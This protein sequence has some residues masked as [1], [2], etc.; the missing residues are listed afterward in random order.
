MSHVA[1]TEDLKGC[2]GAIVYWTFSGLTPFENLEQEWERVGLEKANLPKLPSPEL[3]LS[4]TAHD[5]ASEKFA[6]FARQMGPG[7]WVLVSEAK[8]NPFGDADSNIP[9]ADYT[10]EASLKLAPGGVLKV[11]AVKTKDRDP[12]V[13][14]NYIIHLTLSAQVAYKTNLSKI[15]ASDLGTWLSNYATGQCHAVLL[16]D[17]GGVYFIPREHIQKWNR[18]VAVLNTFGHRIRSIPALQSSEAVE[19][20]LEAVEL[21]AAEELEAIEKVV[22]SGALTSIV[23]R[24]RAA[25]AQKILESVQRYEDLLGKRCESIHTRIEE[26]QANLGAIT[27]V[28]MPE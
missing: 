24:N 22:A 25:K 17:R 26:L 10:I 18:V 1:V 14:D 16:R 3:A 2:A 7:H 20:I 19:A 6:A 21:Q 15:T 4:R 27:L 23:A 11:E 8:N 5:C 9:P 12:T 13:M 28:N